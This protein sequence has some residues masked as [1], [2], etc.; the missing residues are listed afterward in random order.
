MGKTEHSMCQPVL[1]VE[2]TRQM[3]NFVIQ[4]RQRYI[5]SISDTLVGC[6]WIACLTTDNKTYLNPLI[7][8]SFILIKTLCCGRIQSLVLLP[9]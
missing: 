5:V 4:D 3:T 2:I 8:P 1:E 7:I 9:N 6:L